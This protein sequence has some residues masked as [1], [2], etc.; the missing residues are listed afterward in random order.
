LLSGNGVGVLP[1]FLGDEMPELVRVFADRIDVNIGYIV[2]HEALRNTVRV[3]AT[4]DA[5]VKFFSSKQTLF[6]GKKKL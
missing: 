3:H 1:C 6:S 5:L 4:V 2:Y